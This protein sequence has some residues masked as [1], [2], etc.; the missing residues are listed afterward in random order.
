MEEE[1]KIIEKDAYDH[2]HSRG[3]FGLSASNADEMAEI[4]AFLPSFEMEERNE[5]CFDIDFSSSPLPVQEKASL[6]KY[7]K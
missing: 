3:L 4:E 6:L 7:F 5:L 2:V 1:Q